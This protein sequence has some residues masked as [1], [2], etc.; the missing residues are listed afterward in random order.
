MASVSARCDLKKAQIVPRNR[1]TLQEKKQILNDS[2]LLP[3]YFYG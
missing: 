1:K 3:V 2:L